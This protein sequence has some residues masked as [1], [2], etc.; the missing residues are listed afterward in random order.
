M[1][2]NITHQLLISISLGCLLG[3]LLAKFGVASKINPLAFS[4]VWFGFGVLLRRQLIL[5]LLIFL[6]GLNLGLWRG[7]GFF[8][9]VQYIQNQIGSKVTLV[10]RVVDDP[11]YNDFSQIEFHIS[12]IQE[13]SDQA[14]SI[15]GR[16][17]VKT[18][19]GV[20]IGRGDTVRVDGKLSRA[21]GNRH[22]SINYAQVSEVAQSGAKLE[23]IR[24]NFFASTY[25]VLPDPQASLGLGFLVGIHS[26]LPE[27]LLSDLNATGLTHIVA[28]SGY[29]LTI[30]VGLTRRLFAKRS[31][32]QATLAATALMLAFLMIT[33]GSPSIVRASIVSGLGLATWYYGR[34]TSPWMVLLLSAAI[35]ASIDPYFLWYD[36]GWYLSFLAFFGVLILAPAIIKRLYTDHQPRLFGQLF[37]ETTCAQLCVTPLLMAVFNQVSLISILANLIVLPLIPISMI[38]TFIAGAANWV[39]PGVATLIAWPASLILDFIVQVTN[40]LASFPGAGYQISINYTQMVVMFSIILVLALTIKRS[41]D[42]LMV[43]KKLNK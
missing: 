35:S 43:D 6:V 13:V 36:L 42:K 10:G 7:S 39:V 41:A 27:G 31:K 3:L 22:G 24:S 33:G 23:K 26:F 2:K 14:R 11:A 16:M 28:V 20:G 8:A 15:R 40:K 37:I 5:L 38:L 32:Y 25:T 29:N 18:F 34:I 17:R 30:L 19:T 4:F 1:P 21:L 9:D 12:S